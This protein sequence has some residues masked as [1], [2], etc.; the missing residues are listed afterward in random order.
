MQ[1]ISTKVTI[2]ANDVL[3]RVK[4]D[5]GINKVKFASTAI[6]EKDQRE[7]KKK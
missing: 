6:I 1:T 5:R 3:K 2:K 4:K 7:T